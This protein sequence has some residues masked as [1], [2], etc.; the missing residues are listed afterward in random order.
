M[1]SPKD[2]R[3]FTFRDGVLVPDALEA[4]GAEGGIVGHLRDQAA[5][6][7][8]LEGLKR[9][10]ELGLAPTDGATSRRYLPRLMHEYKVSGGHSRDALAEAMRRLM[11]AGRLRRAPVGKDD[12][13]RPLFGLEAV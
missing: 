5:E 4:V 6:R 8:V 11:L 1:R 3:R 2:W 7:A 12:Y 13:R 9:L 10:G